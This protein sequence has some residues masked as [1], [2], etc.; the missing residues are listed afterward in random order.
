MHTTGLY[1]GYILKPSPFDTTG[2]PKSCNC[3]NTYSEEGAYVGKGT[4]YTHMGP[5]QIKYYDTICQM[6]TCKIPYTQAAEEKGIFLKSTHTGA[7]DEIGWDFIELV[8]SVLT[9]MNSLAGIKQQTF[10]QGPSCLSTHLFLGF[11]M[12]CSLQD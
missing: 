11:F 10:I 6:G 9:V 4:V 5:L 3:G 8:P 12:D 2:Q 1:T 7:G